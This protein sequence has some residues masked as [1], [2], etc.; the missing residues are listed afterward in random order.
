MEYFAQT[1][2]ARL[3]GVTD[4]ASL[5]QFLAAVQRKALRTAQISLGDREDALDV[6]QDA[7]IR[8]AERY[9]HKPAEQWAPLF[10]RIL[11][12]RITDCY[13]RRGRDRKLFVATG[14]DTLEATV[15]APASADP[16]HAA[17]RD[18]FG[19]GLEQALAELPLR[20]RQVFLLRIW[21]GLDVAETARVLKVSGGSVKTHLSRAMA[22]LR[23]RLED[24]GHDDI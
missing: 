6:V 5:D 3:D 14:E 21:E 1:F 12:N 23:K 16:L 13:R 15:A 7:M 24:G 22:A 19:D 10:W 4:L 20:Q 18:A 17:G 9:A 8:L 11:H 2:P